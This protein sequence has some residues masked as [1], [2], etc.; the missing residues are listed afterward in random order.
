MQRRKGDLIQIQF[1]AFTRKQWKSKCNRDLVRYQISSSYHPLIILPFPAKQL[2]SMSF[3]VCAAALISSGGRAKSSSVSKA[4]P[5]AGQPLKSKF[6]SSKR[7]ASAQLT[8]FRFASFLIV[9]L[10]KLKYSV[11]RVVFFPDF[12]ILRHSVFRSP[13]SKHPKVTIA[14]LR[15]LPSEHLPSGRRPEGKAISCNHKRYVKKR[16]RLYKHLYCLYCLYYI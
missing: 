3:T 5:R 7:S 11:V 10:L 12:W 15:R 13:W 16:F 1:D 6:R 8:W 9:E 2:N 14:W 4:S